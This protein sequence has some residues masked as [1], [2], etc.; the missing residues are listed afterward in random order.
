MEGPCS[1][2]TSWVVCGSEAPPYDYLNLYGIFNSRF[3]VSF[4]WEMA[5]PKEPY[6]PEEGWGTVSVPLSMRVIM[7]HE[8]WSF[9]SKVRSAKRH[10][11]SFVG[12]GDFYSMFQHTDG[13]RPHSMACRG[14]HGWEFTEPEMIAKII[15]IGSSRRVTSWPCI[16]ACGGAWWHITSHQARRRT[17]WNVA[18]SLATLVSE[19]T[20]LT[21]CL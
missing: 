9:I 10:N 3:C 2:G 5:R 19:G 12:L 6:G 13:N 4:S 21:A 17:H 1:Q 18:S 7:K 11:V 15:R 16:S 20:R 14:Q 8:V